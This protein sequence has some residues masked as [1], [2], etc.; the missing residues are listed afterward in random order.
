M[1]HLL[2]KIRLVASEKRLYHFSFIVALIGI[3][4]LA[5]MKHAPSVPG[6][7]GFDKFNHI[8]AFVVLS[9]LLELS[10]PKVKLVKKI[11][12]LIC[13]GVI[14]EVIQS[15]LSW[16]S[17]ELFDVLADAVGILSFYLVC[18]IYEL[19]NSFIMRKGKFLK[20]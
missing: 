17:A 15:F 7:S 3:L 12:L 1:L 20:E 13:I 2:L 14:I 4:V 8:L 11:V 6:L 16:R 9:F 18:F 19:C 10:Y 5:I